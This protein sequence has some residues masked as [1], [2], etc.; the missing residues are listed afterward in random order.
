MH[1]WNMLPGVRWKYRTQKLRQKLPS[2]HQCTTL[3]GYIFAT[4]ACIDNPK[5]N[6]LN[7]NISS[8]CLYNMVNLSPLTAEI[9][10]RIW[11]TPANFN[12]FRVLASLLQRRRSTEVNQTL[13]D[14][15]RSPALVSLYINEYRTPLSPRRPL[16]ETL[17]VNTVADEHANGPGLMSIATF[18]WKLHAKIVNSEWPI[19][20]Y[21]EGSV[22]ASAANVTGCG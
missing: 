22:V 6:L 9:R 2:V 3:S 17:H 5:K 11:G 1:V 18:W 21:T 10:W 16:S 4:K 7:G 12:E 14:V 15:W 13:P 19:Y 8:I 20:I